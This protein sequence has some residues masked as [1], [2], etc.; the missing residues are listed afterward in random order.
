[1]TEVLQFSGTNRAKSLTNLIRAYDDV[2]AAA[3][4][5]S[6][7]G[8]PNNPIHKVVLVHA[9]RGLGKTRIV[10]ELY[11]HLSEHC[12]LNHYWPDNFEQM[13]DRVA[14][15]PRAET[16]NYEPIIPF[17]WWGMQVP[18]NPN[19]GNTLLSSIDDLLSHLV[20]MR[21]AH[22]RSQNSRSALAEIADVG[23]DI[24]IEIVEAGVDIA[25]ESVGLGIIKRL[26]Q[27]A[28]RIGKLINN[29]AS[30]ANSAEIEGNNNAITVADEVL[31]DLDRVLNPKSKYFAHCPAVIFVDDAQYADLDQP[32]IA[33][34]EKL[35][36]QSARNA[37]PLLLVFTHW[38][39]P[40]KDHLDAEKNQKSKSFLSVALEHA[41]N[42]DNPINAKLSGVKGGAL[43]KENFLKID[44]SDPVDDLSPAITNLFPALASSTVSLIEEKSGGNPRKLEQIIA[45]MARKPKWFD[46]FSMNNDLTP[47]GLAALSILSDLPIEKIV[48]DR[49]LETPL[50]TRGSLAI[51]SSIGSS[52]VID[53]VERLS[54]SQTHK[55]VRANLEEGETVYRFLKNVRD[56][57]RDDIGYFSEPLFF[58][59]ASEYRTNA[60]KDFKDWPS[61]DEIFATLDTLLSQIVDDP[62]SFSNLSEEDLSH[63]LN[64]A[65]DRMM[66]QQQE[67]AGLALAQLVSLENRRSNFEGA[68]I[69]AQKFISGFKP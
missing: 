43:L 44:L 59:A 60:R 21:I 30:D 23:T 15:M 18:D 8:V 32:L 26:G 35:I 65:I 1:M 34:I 41:R 12:D 19:P 33:F 50:D 10:M 66:I 29:T 38:S 13:E 40:L 56:R 42:T 63:A 48:Y 3:E 20:T 57:S 9:E 25:G 64:I 55:D 53:L 37:W 28:F 31:K 5:V 24:G 68:Y 47:E 4:A 61:D 69:A 51:A 39:K 2:A 14:V 11:K 17:L 58:D 62:E 36:E 46:D 52:F 54:K 7:N 67:K 49:L 27:S 45:V 16:C 22:K 6:K